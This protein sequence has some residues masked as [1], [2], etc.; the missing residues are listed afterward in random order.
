MREDQ[1]IQKS[2]DLLLVNVIDP[3]GAELLLRLSTPMRTSN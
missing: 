2:L 3:R 1:W